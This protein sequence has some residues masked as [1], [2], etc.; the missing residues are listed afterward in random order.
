[1][2]HTLTRTAVPVVVTPSVTTPGVPQAEVT[3]T[4]EATGPTAALAG[5]LTVIETPVTGLDSTVNQEDAQVGRN[6][7]TD[8]ALRI[9]RR[10]ELQNA[11]ASV[12]EAIRAKLRTVDGVTQAIVFE[13]DTMVTSPDGIPPKSLECF[14]E[15]GLNA[16]IAAMLWQAKAG[17]IHLHGDITVVVVDSMGISHDIKFSRPVQKLVYVI[18]DITKDTT[19]P[20]TGADLIKGYILEYAAAL[21]IGNDVLTYPALLP[22]F[23]NKVPG[24]VDIAIKVG[25]VNPPVSDANIPIAVNEIA[26][27]DSGR[28][29]VNVA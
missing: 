5:S 2:T 4:A 20:A 15:G 27:F 21:Q 17:G 29:T 6:V 19:F 10:D 26:L 12:V 18:V 28:I 1:V 14:V 24:I 25:L 16:D 7:E 3:M 11:G 9:R 13:N 23:A 22:S 8:S